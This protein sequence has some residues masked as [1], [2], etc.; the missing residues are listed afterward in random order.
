MT[1]SF[2]NRKSA[3]H[4]PYL[5]IYIYI[6]NVVPYHFYHAKIINTVTNN[7]ERIAIKI[8]LAA[9]LRASQPGVQSASLIMTSLMTS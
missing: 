4:P 7:K 5:L 6:Q 2:G 9:T 3:F 1:T 8:K